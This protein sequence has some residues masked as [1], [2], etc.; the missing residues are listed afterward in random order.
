MPGSFII[1]IRKRLWSFD[2]FLIMSE[3]KPL[4]LVSGFRV[5]CFNSKEISVQKITFW[6]FHV[7]KVLKTTIDKLFILRKQK[8]AKEN[9][10]GDYMDDYQYN[11]ISYGWDNLH[12][13][14]KEKGRTR[15]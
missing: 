8:E 12:N 10:S 1:R 3:I 14:F 9:E 5:W 11:N 7:A 13:S 6:N 2:K 4:T 15:T